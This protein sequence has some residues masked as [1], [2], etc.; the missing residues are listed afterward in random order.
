M[1]GVVEIEVMLARRELLTENSF[2]KPLSML[3]AVSMPSSGN[4]YNTKLGELIY[5]VN[6]ECQL[7]MYDRP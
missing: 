4:E 3:S 2:L 5:S 6:R 7:V 1:V